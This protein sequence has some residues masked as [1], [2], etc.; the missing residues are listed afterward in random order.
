[1]KF[2]QIALF[3][4]LFGSGETNAFLKKL[5]GGGGNDNK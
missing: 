2:S 3:I 4:V 1:M 5:F